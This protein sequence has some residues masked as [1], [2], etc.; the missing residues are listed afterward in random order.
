MIA[1]DGTSAI[2]RPTSSAT[3]AREVAI[4]EAPHTS[5]P[6]KTT[7]PPV[8]VRVP[9]P[10]VSGLKTR[11]MHKTTLEVRFRIV[12]KARVRLVGRKGSKIV[13]HTKLKVLAP[14]MHKLLLKLNRKKWP[15]KIELQTHA[16]E[17]L[18]TVVQGG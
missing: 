18:P 15:T 10:L 3:I 9:V 17:P 11:L 5:P 1:P 7:P 16:L 8:V 14:G 4:P 13:A 2:P 12:V 6:P